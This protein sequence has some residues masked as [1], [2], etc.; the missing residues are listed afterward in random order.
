M[1]EKREFEPVPEK[2]VAAAK[3]LI[4]ER[5]NHEIIAVEEGLLGGNPGIVSTDGTT[6]HIS[7]I[8]WHV[9]DDLDNPFDPVCGF[10]YT[11]EEQLEISEP[12]RGEGE[13]VTFDIIEFAIV[14]TG[15]A[16]VRTVW[17]AQEGVPE[18]I[19]EDFEKN[20]AS[21]ISEMLE[22]GEEIPDGLI[23]KSEEDGT[24]EFTGRFDD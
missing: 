22:N 20:I 24:P 15:H 21:R 10:P 12:Y 17:N 9:A 1:T 8:R 19:S 23:G 6:V 16:I 11:E 13:N 4:H 3:R 18:D 14:G 7:E 5:T 2:V